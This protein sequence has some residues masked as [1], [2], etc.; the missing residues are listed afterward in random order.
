MT[1]NDRR[2]AGYDVVLMS[3]FDTACMITANAGKVRWPDGDM[4][5]FHTPESA[6][7]YARIHLQHEAAMP[8]RYGVAKYARDF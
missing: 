3:V 2:G 8:S 1:S 5:Y 7:E 6:D 4:R